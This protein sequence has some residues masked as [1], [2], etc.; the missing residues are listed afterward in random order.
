MAV[1]K[2]V[3]V[4]FLAGAVLGAVVGTLIAQKFVPWYW[5]PGNVAQGTINLSTDASAGVSGDSLTKYDPAA[6]AAPAAADDLT[7]ERRLRGMGKAPV[8]GQV[9]GGDSI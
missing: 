6:K 4:L 8:G 3:V 2:R 7:K 9:V 1:F 5:T